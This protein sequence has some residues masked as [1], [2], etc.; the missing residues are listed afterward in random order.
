MENITEPPLGIMPKSIWIELRI[1]NLCIA[2]NNFI[3]ANKINDDVQEWIK[4]VVDHCIIQIHE[5]VKLPLQ[6]KI[7]SVTQKVFTY[8]K[9]NKQQFAV[10]VKNIVVKNDIA[11][12][13]IVKK[14]ATYSIN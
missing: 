2:I 5:F 7:E 10:L 4:E 8:T 12:I 3:D 14:Y 13:K 9:T 6:Q 1:K 11:K